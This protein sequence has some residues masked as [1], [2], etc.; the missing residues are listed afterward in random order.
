VSA[1]ERAGVDAAILGPWVLKTDVAETIRR[2]R[3]HR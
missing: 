1:L 2:L 3:G